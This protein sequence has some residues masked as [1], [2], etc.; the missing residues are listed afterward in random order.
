MDIGCA[1]C[2]KS[3]RRWEPARFQSHQCKKLFVTAGPKRVANVMKFILKALLRAH[4]FSFS[5]AILTLWGSSVFGDVSTVM[6]QNNMVLQREKPLPVFGHAAPDEEVTVEFNGQTKTTKAAGDGKWQVTLD[7]MKEGGPFVMTIKGTN[8]LT[9]SNVMVGEV[10]LCAGQSNMGYSMKKIG[11]RNT[12]AAAQANFPNIHI[13]TMTRGQH[14]R[15]E[16]ITPEVCLRSSATAYYFG[17]NLYS[18]L[19][20]PIG[21]IVS[22]SPGTSIRYWVDPVTI[23][24]DAKLAG[25]KSV[26]K[27]YNELVEPVIPY[28]IR[29]TIWYQGESD[30]DSNAQ[31]Y[32]SRF[33]SLI[34]NYR[35]NWNEGDFPFLFVQLASFGE[36]QTNA[37]A[38]SGWAEIRD[39]QTQA[40]ALSNTAMAVT[41]DIGARDFHP[42]NKWDVGR[43]LAL[44][45]L[46]LVYGRKDISEYSGPTLQS[47]EKKGGAIYL[48]FNH[49][50]GGLVDKDK[51]DLSGFAVCGADNQWHWARGAIQHD[52]VR[53][54]CDAV[55]DPVKVRYAWADCPIATP[56]YN[57]AGLPAVPFQT[58]VRP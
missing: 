22:S 58:E 33:L 17:T 55:K 18:G 43:R 46:R 29:G 31:E 23:A 56:L 34:N 16:T 6:F 13:C 14:A 4:A 53:L 41:V 21:L 20:V 49:T 12:N 44:P 45:A 32:K 28:G 27:W 57:G 40:L 51:D 8:T 7:P 35:K 37:G 26:G 54:T 52:T 19:N 24:A 47:C 15:W 2:R 3:V 38:A 25:Q 9:F 42:E 1:G 30:T 39:V 48:H 5:F 36:T 10:W 11:G 50:Y